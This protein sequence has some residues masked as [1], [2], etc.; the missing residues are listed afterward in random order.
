M[1]PITLCNKTTSAPGLSSAVNS[2]QV[3]SALFSTS[4]F[5]LKLSAFFLKM[6]LLFWYRIGVNQETNEKLLKRLKT[7]MFICVSA[8]LLL[9]SLS[10]LQTSSFSPTTFS[11]SWLRGGPGL[12]GPYAAR[13]RQ[14][15]RNNVDFGTSW[16]LHFLLPS[17]PFWLL[18]SHHSY[19]H[20][21][22]W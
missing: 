6:F 16:L 15:G 7:Q 9:V 19:C 13:W 10:A 3:F 8:L 11:T 18:S 21:P 17:S 1:A 5:V 20:L 2:P 4:V 22:F 12:A 14:S